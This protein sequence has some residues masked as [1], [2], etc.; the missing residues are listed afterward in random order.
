MI[1]YVLNVMIF[2]THEPTM[3]IL[4]FDVEG[5]AKSVQDRNSDFKMEYTL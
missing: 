4:G 1:K 5:A 3:S 2:C